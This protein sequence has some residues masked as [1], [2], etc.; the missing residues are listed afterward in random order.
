MRRA[1]WFLGDNRQA[2]RLLVL[3]GAALAVVAFVVLSQAKGDA[4]PSFV[5]AVEGETL[6]AQLDTQTV[7][8]SRDTAGDVRWNL[9]TYD[10]SS[11]TCLDLYYTGPDGDGMVG[12]CG[13][14]DERFPEASVIGWVDTN[15]DGTAQMVMMGVVAEDQGITSVSIEFQDG[16]TIS[17]PVV[18]QSWFV[19]DIVGSPVSSVAYDAAGNEV[20][21]DD[22]VAATVAELDTARLPY[23]SQPAA[24][25]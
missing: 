17:A 2:M 23:Q 18:N 10:S 21:R 7:V 16:T 20:S 1:S 9:V 4:S 14:T 6:T 13:P 25:S 24:G 8:Q 12:G 19:F 5:S 11:G 22:S 3:L 15:N